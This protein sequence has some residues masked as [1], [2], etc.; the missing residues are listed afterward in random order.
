MTPLRNTQPAPG[1]TLLSLDRPDVHN[2]LDAELVAELRKY[3]GEAAADD[4]TRAIVLGSTTPGMFCAGADLTVSDAERRVISDE[5]YA[6]YEQ[7]ITLPVP[8][9][10][11]VDGAAVG[12]GSQLALAADVR[13]GSTNARFRFV[14][15]GH[16]LVV[17]MWALP[18][19]VGR[20]AMELV[21]SQ[22][23][24]ASDEAVTIGLLDRLVEDP[25]AE[26][27]AFAGTV[28]ELDPLAVARA[29]ERA[30]QDEQLIAR[31]AEERAGNAAV[32]TGAVGRRPLNR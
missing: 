8:I 2:A 6:L 7:M 23:F 24:V 22:R 3:I 4:A 27:M 5:L 21:L 13:L 29:K 18:S 30:V 11:A 16:G 20:R 14:G 10:A 1:V 15:P 31:L 12:G 19:T 25:L 32:F 26:A 28:T 9:A 17:G